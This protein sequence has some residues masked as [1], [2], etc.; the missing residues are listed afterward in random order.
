M[1]EYWNDLGTPAQRPT[2]STADAVY[3]PRKSPVH[4]RR[5]LE[6]DTS[7]R[8]QVPDPVNRTPVHPPGVANATGGTAPTSAGGTSTGGAAKQGT[9]RA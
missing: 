6:T 1:R 2:N 3:R 9:E 8:L 7:T 4:T 5:R